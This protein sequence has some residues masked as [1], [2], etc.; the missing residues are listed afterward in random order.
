ME[1]SHNTPRVNASLGDQKSPGFLALVKSNK[2][3]NEQSPETKSAAEQPE[4][5][6][7]QGSVEKVEDLDEVVKNLNDQVQTVQRSLQFSVDEDTGKQIVTVRD[8]NTNDV[9]RQL[10]S[11]EALELSKRMMEKEKSGNNANI[12]S[13]FSSIA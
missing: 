9:I 8:A 7:E 10:P 3:G 2:T 6:E 11:E 1:I 5:K 12:S 4:T 13:L